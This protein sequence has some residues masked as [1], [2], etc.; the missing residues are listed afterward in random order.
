[1]L[2]YPSNHLPPIQGSLGGGADYLNSARIYGDRVKGAT[3]YTDFWKDAAAVPPA[4]ME[5]YNKQYATDI[6]TDN[7]VSILKKH[8]DQTTHSAN[9]GADQPSDLSRPI[10]IH[11]AHQAPHGPYMAPKE[12]IL[13][14]GAESAD[15]SACIESDTSQCC[16]ANRKSDTAWM[17][18]VYLAMVTSMDDGIGKVVETLKAES[19]YAN[20]LIIFSSDNGGISL[21]SWKPGPASNGAVRGGKASYYDGGVRVVAFASGGAL[22]GKA[23]G[24]RRG[25]LM[26]IAD[27]YATFGNPALAGYDAADPRAAAAGLPPPDSIDMWPFLA[28]DAESPR[29]EVPLKGVSYD[30]GKQHQHVLIQTINGSVYK[31]LIGSALSGEGVAETA[32]ELYN[33]SAA[34]SERVNLVK[35]LA[36]AALDAAPAPAPTEARCQPFCY[37]NL[38]TPWPTKCGWKNCKTCPEIIA[39]CTA[40]PTP[41]PTPR[42]EVWAVMLNRVRELMPTYYQAPVSDEL[43]SR[44]ADAAEHC[45]GGSYGPF[46]VTGPADDAVASAI[47]YPSR[48]L[49]LAWVA[50]NATAADGKS[51]GGGGGI[52]STDMEACERRRGNRPVP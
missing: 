4:E 40:A 3:S 34:P 6:Y 7:V 9:V 27:L 19:L 2:C 8:G 24:T 25:G 47:E 51:G 29:L 44:C 46:L 13:K 23:R 33:L 31:I 32:F 1:M 50:P 21:N 18:Q 5:A 41:T 42:M 39:A 52:G 10:F 28:G 37:N 20:T 30:D 49:D 48:C 45:Y 16:T 11:L 14:Y 43:D 35:G 12:T 26:H 15:A 38:V 22:P 36:V 17:R